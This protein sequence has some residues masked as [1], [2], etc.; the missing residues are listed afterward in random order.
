MRI[1]RFDNNRLGIVEGDEIIDVSAVLDKLPKLSWPYPRYDVF[2]ACFGDLRPEM[3]KLA[4]SGRRLKLGEVMLLS[5]V[6]NPGKIIA[7]P[8]NYKLHLEESRADSGI[9][10]GSKVKTIEE[11]GVFLKSNSSLVGAGEGVVSDRR[12]RRTDHEIELGLVIGRR[13]KNI[14][15]ADAF[16]YVVG[17]T[18]ALD[19]TIRGPEER[20]LRKSRDT[21]SVL[22]PWLVTADEFGDPSSVDFELKIAGATRQ[23]ANT[24]DLI[25]DCRK[26]ISYSSDAYTLEPG[27]VIMTGT[28]EGVA[29]V[30]PGDVMDCWIDRIG[31]MQVAVRAP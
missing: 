26:L 9:H 25:F 10:F 23:K 1:C 30:E 12:D 28:P 29:P 19:M 13:G 15:E 22:G 6:A 14:S 8:V 11:C 20:S 5:P 31:R 3:E 24:R 7:A 16:D 4:K 21:F 18:I 2:I 27:D 17:Y